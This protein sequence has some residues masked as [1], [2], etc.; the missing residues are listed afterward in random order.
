[1]TKSKKTRVLAFGTFDHLHAGHENYL[2]QAAAL[3]DELYVIIA[4][5]RTA[6]TI[7]GFKPDHKEKARTK[8]VNALSFV[9]KALLGN[10][11]DKY[12]V[13]SKF[14]PDVI[15]L[16]YDQFVFTHNLNKRLI[17]LKLNT[18]IIRLPS[19]EPQVYKSSLIRA[20]QAEEREK[21]LI[22]GL[23]KKLSPIPATD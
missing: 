11:E 19:Y 12:K 20:R 18:K 17:D 13:L 9:T 16:G 15:A 8:T 23:P 14:K 10:Q 3:G 4:R 5:D 2:K 1:M 6:Q 7:R 22:V 21:T